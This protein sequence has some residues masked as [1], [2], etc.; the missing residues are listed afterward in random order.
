VNWEHKQIKER[1]QH[2]WEEDMKTSCTELKTALEV[3]ATFGGE[4]VIEI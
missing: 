4:E 2:G 3:M 1:C